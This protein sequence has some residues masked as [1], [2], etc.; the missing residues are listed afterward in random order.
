M[1]QTDI[2]KYLDT[3]T[4]KQAD[5]IQQLEE[6]AEQNHVPIMDKQGIALLQQLIR[7]YQ[8]T[9]ILEIGTAIGYSALR[10]LEAKPNVQVVSIERNQEMYDRAMKNIQDQNQEEHIDV[11]FGDALEVD[12]KITEK[13]PYQMIFID[14]AKG[15]YRHFFERYGQTLTEKGMIVTDNV[16]FRGLVVNPEDAP[17]R[18]RKLANKIDQY[19]QW[20][21]QHSSYHTTILPVGDGV[22]VSVK[23]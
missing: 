18:L 22:A 17:K 3:I 1:N 23:K 8:P 2:I 16:L 12:E 11:I 14:A 13:G 6:E 10:M 21:L 20:L 4:P 19:N 5:W 7:L 9:K 15:Q